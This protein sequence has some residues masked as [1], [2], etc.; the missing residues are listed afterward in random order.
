MKSLYRKVFHTVVIGHPSIMCYLRLLSVVK[1]SEVRFDKP[2]LESMC[3][4][5]PLELKLEV[6][7]ISLKR[8]ARIGEIP[9]DSLHPFVVEH[10]KKFLNLLGSLVSIPLVCEHEEDGTFGHL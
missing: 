6:P 5:V 3:Y 4:M 10:A 9:L 1:L 7:D 2:V 8:I